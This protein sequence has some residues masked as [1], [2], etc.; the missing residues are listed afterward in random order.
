M[1]FLKGLNL[2]PSVYPDAIHGEEADMIPY[3]KK[4]ASDLETVESEND[5][6]DYFEAA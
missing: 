6:I 1:V 2:V 5:L 3:H 4:T